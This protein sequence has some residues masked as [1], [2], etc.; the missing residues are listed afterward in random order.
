MPLTNLS[1]RKSSRKQRERGA[2]FY[3]TAEDLAAAGFP[4]GADPPYFTVYAKQRSVNART[5]ILSL[6]EQA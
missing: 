2:W 3:L 5:V 6:Y 4:I 1:R